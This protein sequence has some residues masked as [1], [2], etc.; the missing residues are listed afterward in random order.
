MVFGNRHRAVALSIHHRS[1]DHL[2]SRGI[3]EPS[4][5]GYPAVLSSEPVLPHLRLSFRLGN[6]LCAPPQETTGVF[7]NGGAG[8][9]NCVRRVIVPSKSKA[10]VPGHGVAKEG[11]SGSAVLFK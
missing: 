10:L 6:L 11:Q 2:L 3:P 4:G 7:A 5:F 1:N 9:S 8:I